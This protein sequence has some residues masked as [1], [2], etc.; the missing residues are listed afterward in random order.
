MKYIRCLLSFAWLFLPQLVLADS[1]GFLGRPSPSQQEAS[2]HG[3]QAGLM[4]GPG[5]TGT[6]KLGYWNHTANIT[7]GARTYNSDYGWC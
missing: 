2:V 7:V 5:I 1:P 4:D 3:H 6:Y